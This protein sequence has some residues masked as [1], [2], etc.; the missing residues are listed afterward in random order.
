MKLPNLSY[1]MSVGELRYIQAHFETAESRNPDTMVGAFVPFAKRLRCLVRGTLFSSR[2]KANPFY[3]YVLA[4]TRYYD[5][6]FQSAI[7]D[8]VSCIV[9]IGCGS[10]T[11]AHRFAAELAQKKIKVIECD[12]PEAISAKQHVA[13]REWPADPVVYLPLDLN[14]QG[15]PPLV[16]ALREHLDR[17]VLIM[18]EGVSPYVNAS[19]FDNFL[20]LLSSTLHRGS[21]VAYDFKLRGV[22]DEFGRSERSQQL[23]RLSSDK[24]EVAAHHRALGFELTH[25]EL[26]PALSQRLAPRALASAKSAFDEDCLV[27]LV[28]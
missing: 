3:S 28:V 8:S 26:G 6:V 19:A 1:M 10:D 5:G 16:A 9:N 2:V 13:N 7:N 24:D 27:Q 17:P 4:R 21:R 15:C 25:M 18:L 11:R 23:F 22:A 20:R 12:Q 14:E